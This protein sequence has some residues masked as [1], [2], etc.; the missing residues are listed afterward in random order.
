MNLLIKPQKDSQ[1]I[2]SATPASAG[3]R[4]ISFS[5]YQLAPGETLTLSDSSNEL[6]AVVLSGIVSAQ[7]EGHDWSEIG[8]RMSVFEDAAPYAVYVPPRSK[9]TIT[10]KANAELGVAGGPAKGELPGWLIEPAT[11]RRSGVL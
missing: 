2:V 10:A 3:W 5:A 6:C 9:L 11:M 8:Q 4:Y 1:Q 7:T